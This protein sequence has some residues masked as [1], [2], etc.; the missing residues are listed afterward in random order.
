[1]KSIVQ[2]SKECN[3]NYAMVARVIKVNK[4]E[5]H[6]INNFLFIDEYQEDLLHFCLYRLG[7]LEFVTF[8]S[9]M[10]IE[11]SFENF[12]KRVYN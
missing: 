9:K 5:P 10:N 2:I 12:K 1:M 11:E 7:I 3:L 4:I 6:R 8:E